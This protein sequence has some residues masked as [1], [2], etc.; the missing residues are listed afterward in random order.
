MPQGTPAGKSQLILDEARSLS[1]EEIAVVS[2]GNPELCQA[3]W[4]MFILWQLV[5]LIKP[6]PDA[7]LYVSGKG[8][9][10]KFF[11]FEW[12]L[13]EIGRDEIFSSFVCSAKAVAECWKTSTPKWT[14]ALS[15]FEKQVDISI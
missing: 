13:S 4:T 2:R 6:T 1:A 14:T 10:G 11:V 5:F 9:F 7:S 15:I 8:K 12:W 3:L